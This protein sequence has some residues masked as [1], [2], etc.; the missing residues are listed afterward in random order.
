M[1][2]QK[3]KY[4]GPERRREYCPVHH[5]KCQEIKDARTET[6]RRVPIW[7]FTLVVG[8]LITAQGILINIAIRSNE[9]S[10]AT[11]TEHIRTSDRILNNLNILKE[12]KIFLVLLCGELFF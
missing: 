5:I 10:N 9:K 8:M 12:I 2:K 11:L 4:D 7:V 1:D 3:T 6:R